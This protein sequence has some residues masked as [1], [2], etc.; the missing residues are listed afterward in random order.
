MIDYI[1][2]L[3]NDHKFITNW[4]FKLKMS[5]NPDPSKQTVEVICFLKKTYFSKLP[6][7][8]LIKLQF[9][10]KKHINTEWPLVMEIMEIMES[11]G[12][13]FG[14]G[15]SHGIPKIFLIVMEKSWKF[16]Y[17]DYSFFL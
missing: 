1:C 14:H 13:F 15:K 17:K 3:I 5:F 16:F 12:T 9:Y 7:L 6:I 8:T 4:V 10:L 11:H 2:V